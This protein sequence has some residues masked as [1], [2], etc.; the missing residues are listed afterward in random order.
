MW[1]SIRFEALGIVKV[2]KDLGEWRNIESIGRPDR[3][4]WYKAR[5][6]IIAGSAC[7]ADSAML[8]PHISTFKDRTLKLTRNALDPAIITVV[9]YPVFNVKNDRLVLDWFEK[10][11]WTIDFWLGIDLRVRSIHSL[12]NATSTS[13]S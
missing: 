4:C 7:L 13:T 3:R 1:R 2:L 11:R 8:Y 10:H 5:G 9:R 12:S 6:S